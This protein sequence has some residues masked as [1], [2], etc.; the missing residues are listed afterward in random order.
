MNLKKNILYSVCLV[1]V[2][3]TLIKFGLQAP[4]QS[5]AE[6]DAFWTN[7][8]HLSKKYDIL[9][10]GDSRIYRGVN[11]K[12]F[13]ASQ[14][15][16]NL[17]LSSGGFSEEYIDYALNSLN[18]NGTIYL[19]ITPH[20]ITKE[21]LRNIHFNQFR[22]VEEFEVFKRRYIE[23][24]LSFFSPYKVNKLKLAGHSVNTNQYYHNDGWVESF[25]SS[26]DT[27]RAVRLYT[28]T[29]SKYQVTDDDIIN[30]KKALKQLKDSN[31]KLI[32]FAPPISKSL[33]NLE[34]SISGITR[35]EL[36]TI[37]INN[38]I[39]WFD[40]PENKFKSYDG[41]H[42]NSENANAFSD[43]LVKESYK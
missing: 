14:T 33:A 5:K 21:A 8:A 41:S 42:L 4:R 29:Y 31:A 7:K 6:I 40:I 43:H 34:D 16:Y 37:V 36:K 15:A 30:F 17:G 35:K 26:A 20:S 18:N 25:E 9:T 10:I 27:N 24:F 2:F 13:P 11:T 38:G 22:E 12:A 39:D 19:G 32:A 23:P 28:K 3:T 1:I